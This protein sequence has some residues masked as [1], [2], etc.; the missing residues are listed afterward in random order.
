M[1]PEKI[2]KAPTGNMV[3]CVMADYYIYLFPVGA[4]IFLLKVQPQALT[5]S[6]DLC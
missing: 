2:E 3:G 1:G 5:K 6:Y 4:S